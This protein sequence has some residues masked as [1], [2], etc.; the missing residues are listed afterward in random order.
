MRL[1]RKHL[2][3]KFRN[4]TVRVAREPYDDHHWKVDNPYTGYM[5][6]G[7]SLEP[8]TWKPWGFG[9]TM[10][11]DNPGCLQNFLQARIALGMFSMKVEITCRR[12]LRR[13]REIAYTTRRRSRRRIHRLKKRAHPY[14]RAAS[15]AL[16]MANGREPHPDTL[17]ATIAMMS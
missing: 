2:P 4:L 5:G 9:E 11:L 17:L 6:S 14:V 7:L 13:I 15:M 1:D 10:P 16:D 3:L 12:V 8:D